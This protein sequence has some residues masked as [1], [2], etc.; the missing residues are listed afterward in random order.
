MVRQTSYPLFLYLYNGIYNEL[1][2]LYNALYNGPFRLLVSLPK[3]YVFTSRGAVWLYE[4]AEVLYD[5]AVSEELRPPDF[6]VLEL[7][8]RG[9]VGSSYYPNEAE[10]VIYLG[11]EVYRPYS[12]G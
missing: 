3:F 2:K 4:E 9:E 6:P 7:T 1:Y 11:P 12:I 5:P 8:G 10:H